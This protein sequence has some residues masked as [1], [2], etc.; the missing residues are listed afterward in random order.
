MLRFI[1]LFVRYVVAIIVA[2]FVS[3][4]VFFVGGALT[5]AIFEELPVWMA[6]IGMGV[7]FAIVG[8]CG[9]RVGGL[10]LEHESR[11]H[12]SVL[13]LLLGLGVHAWIILMAKY[14][15]AGDSVFVWLLPLAIGGAV[16]VRSF[17]L[18]HPPNQPLQ[19]DA[20]VRR[21]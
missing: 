21:S 8:F 6:A 3:F 20:A 5:F 13:L 14:R 4:S 15:E 17:I 2:Y 16:A 11:R 1:I 9:V 10:C 19:R 12:G 7:L 18:R